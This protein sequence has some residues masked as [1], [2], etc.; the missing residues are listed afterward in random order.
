MDGKTVALYFDDLWALLM[1]HLQNT[2]TGVSESLNMAIK[3][4][5]PLLQ[6]FEIFF[7][8]FSGRHV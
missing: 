7:F 2:P 6:T 8:F 3:A 1:I 5:S 4:F